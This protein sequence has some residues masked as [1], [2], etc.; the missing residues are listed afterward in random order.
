MT[1][2]TNIYALVDP[3]TELVRY[4][5]K[6]DNPRLRFKTHV[7]DARRLAR[8]SR[9]QAWICELDRI[10]LIPRLVI[11]E[12]TAQSDASRCE[13]KW[14]AHYRPQGNLCNVRD[15]CYPIRH[16]VHMRWRNGRRAT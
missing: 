12:R 10:G 1:E 15:K 11:L 7:S 13:E 8:K 5:G 3:R 2:T 14:I 6:S 4:V 9:L 16:W